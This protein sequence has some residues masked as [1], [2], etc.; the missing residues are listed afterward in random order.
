[1]KRTASKTETPE[2]TPS[3]QG[4]GAEAPTPGSKTT[5]SHLARLT[6]KQGI[7]IKE[8]QA[9]DFFGRVIK[10]IM[11]KNRTWIVDT[12]SACLR[13]NQKFLKQ[14]QYVLEINKPDK[15]SFISDCLRIFD[16]ARV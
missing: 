8:K 1:L 15:K 11:V 4:K 2:T 6:P 16:I 14:Y 7:L 3:K 13:K 12:P 9:T 10:V 5:T